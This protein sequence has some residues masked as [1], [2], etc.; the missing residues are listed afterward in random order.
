MVCCLPK[1][2]ERISQSVP[3]LGKSVTTSKGGGRV[4]LVDLHAADG[5]FAEW[6]SKHWLPRVFDGK[7]WRKGTSMTQV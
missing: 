4:E 6:K 2:Q 1:A 5:S 7:V 3:G